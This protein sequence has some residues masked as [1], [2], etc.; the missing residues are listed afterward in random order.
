MASYC[1]FLG[2][3]PQLSV[4]ELAMQF[5]DFAVIKRFPKHVIVFETSAEIGQKQFDRLGGTIL[6]AEGIKELGNTE[7][8]ADALVNGTANVKGKV[9]FAIRTVGI[10]KNT[11]HDLYR[12]GKNALKKAGRSARYVGNE[13]EP[14]A[15]ALLKDAELINGK[16]GAE[17]VLLH[18]QESGVFW[19]G[20]TVAAQDLDAYTK[21]DMKKPVRDTRVGLLPP[22][23]AQILLNGGEWLA[24]SAN[25][26]LPKKLTVL[27]PFCGTGVI[28]LE[29]LLRHWTVHGS[30]ASLKAVNGTLKNLEWARKEYG[31][32]KKEVSASIWKQDAT[33]PF[34][35]KELP[36]LIATETTLGPPLVV[37]PAIKDAQKMRTAVEETEIAFLKNVR[38]T[39]PGVPVA[40]T[41][42][43][44]MVS[45]GPMVLERLWKELP[46][47]GFEAVLPAGLQ[48]DF[49]GRA[50]LLY[51]RG[52][53]VVGREFVFLR[54]R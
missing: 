34:A 2:N 40:L 9:T 25:P 11:V 13:H 36:H 26:K 4:A 3:H 17:F 31:I 38:K 47:L 42:P 16:G 30:D 52:D 35:M 22:K 5:A 41:L 39:L 7:R 21:R 49:P 37:R 8:F 32:P 28:P 50:S 1:A 46:D 27:D 43:V 29:A 51:R 15:L 48:G 18:D 24:R 20:K 33:K 10:D 23:L 44:W 54:Q 14:A 12:I 19:G 45:S 53:A 6:I